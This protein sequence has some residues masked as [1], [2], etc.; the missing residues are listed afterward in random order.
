MISFR[1]I[2]RAL[3][4]LEIDP[5]RPVIVHPNPQ[6]SGLISGGAATLLGALLAVFPRLITP[7]FTPQTMIIPESGPEKNAI[8][9][10]SGAD[11]NR[12]AVFFHPQLSPDPLLGPLPEFIRTQPGAERS[13][14][15]L[16]SFTGLGMR[17]TLAA[18]SIQD[19]YAPIKILTRQAGYA[20]LIGGNQ[21]MNFSLHY[22]V[23]T[24][25][26]EGFTRWALTPFGVALC[27]QMPGCSNGFPALDQEL[28]ERTRSSELGGLQVRA[29]ALPDLVKTVQTRLEKDPL[30]LLCSDPGCACCNAVRQKQV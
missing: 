10:G 22:A 14:H 7:A 30:A 12:A 19:P 21:T 28:A 8:Q 3:I 11:N 16:L 13:S 9:Y 20:V 24:A 1:Q 18:Q 15:P 26:R 5:R 6:I 4:S 17:E 23:R 29:Y 2:Q 25:G 27:P